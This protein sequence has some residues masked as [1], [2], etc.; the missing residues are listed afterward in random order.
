MQSEILELIFSGESQSLELKTS[1]RDPSILAK[2]IGSFANSQ[3]GKIIIGV[4]EPLEIVGI[5]ELLTRRV[6]EAACRRLT[7]EPKTKL[8][9]IEADGKRVAVIDVERSKEIVLSEGSAYVR[10]G[11]LTQP[12]A[13]KQMRQHLPPQPD[14]STIE[15]LTKAIERQSKLIEEMHEQNRKSNS[16]QARCKQ[17]GIGFFLGVA[18]SVIASIVYALLTVNFRGYLDSI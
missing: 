7:P 1:I 5:D 3:G 10:Q 13:W 8:S 17:Q 11:T 16:W 2:L 12:M 9:I 14:A 4:T 15:S 18:A 6:Y